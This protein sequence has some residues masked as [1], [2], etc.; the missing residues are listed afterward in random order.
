MS[1]LF[2]TRLSTCVYA[3]MTETKGCIAYR[4]S[5]LLILLG[6]GLAWLGS[7]LGLDSPLFVNIGGEHGLELGFV[8]VD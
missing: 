3:L 7:G 8:G 2:S 6:L 1:C 5:Y 4:G